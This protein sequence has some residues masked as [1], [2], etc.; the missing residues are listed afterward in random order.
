MSNGDMANKYSDGSMAAPPY[1]TT[2]QNI[3]EDACG[4]P[5]DE[6]KN[7]SKQGKRLMKT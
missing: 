6:V 4:K 2:K 7:K 1:N 3:L 5:Q